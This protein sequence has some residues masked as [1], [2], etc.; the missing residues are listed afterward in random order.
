MEFTFDFSVFACFGC[1][2]LLLSFTLFCLS[3]AVLCLAPCRLV[4]SYK[5]RHSFRALD[6]LLSV[7]SHK[8]KWQLLNLIKLIPGTKHVNAIFRHRGSPML[9]NLCGRQFITQKIFISLD[10]YSSFH[11]FF[12]F[13]RSGGVFLRALFSCSGFSLLKR[14]EL[15][16]RLVM[17][18]TSR[19][20]HKT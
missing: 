10:F 19:L 4:I 17:N 6:I 15:F 18:R 14:V 12:S 9:V 2:F 1:F 8:R 11:G 20:I 3:L 7:W 13:Y 16:S 5:V